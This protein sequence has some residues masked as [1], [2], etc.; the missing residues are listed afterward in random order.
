MLVKEGEKWDQNAKAMSFCVRVRMC[1]CSLSGMLVKIKE[2]HRVTMDFCTA[3][4]AR[5]ELGKVGIVKAEVGKTAD[6]R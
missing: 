2:Q 6:H 5:S 1:G 3:L 4:V